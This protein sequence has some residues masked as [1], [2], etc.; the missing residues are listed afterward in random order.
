M[1]ILLTLN[2]TYRGR[3]DAGYW[4]TY[5]P[6]RQLG[7]EVY[8][9]DTVDPEERNFDKII[10]EFKPDLIFCCM[11]GDPNITPW[12]PWAE[13]KKETE[14]GRTKTFN[15]FC[16]DT[17]RFDSF[18]IEACES[19]NVCSTPE[20]NFIQSYKDAGY[21]NILLGCWHANSEVYPKKEFTQKD[22]DLSFV[23]Y[24]TNERKNFFR[25]AK[26]NN[27]SI[28]NIYGI[29]YEEMFKL[30]SR[31][32]IGINLSVNDNDSKRKT[33]M[34]QRMFEIPAGGGMLLT[35]YH[36]NIEQFYEIDKEIVTFETL[37]EFVKKADFLLKRQNLVR[38]ISENGH[39]RFLAEH[40]SKL[41]LQ[42]IIGRIVAC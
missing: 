13:I 9:Y 7:H 29:S 32:R 10:E 17:W 39:R 21:K 30:Y 37:D 19:F 8:W 42:D 20:P 11:T 6:L 24:P 4:Y 1:K 22:I 14:S 38:Q 15:W 27:I 31:S 33:Q 35:Q 28:T 12:E 16:D 26:L 25:V 40:E 5:L 2:K 36:K 34:K 41:R 18:S 3:P 23:G